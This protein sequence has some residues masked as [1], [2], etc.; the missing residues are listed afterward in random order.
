METNYHHNQGGV[1]KDVGNKRYL[2]NNLYNQQINLQETSNIESGHDDDIGVQREYIMNELVNDEALLNDFLQF[3]QQQAQYRIQKTGHNLIPYYENVSSNK[4]VTRKQLN[5]SKKLQSMVQ[6]QPDVSTP[7]KRRL[8][9]SAGSGGLPTPKQQ[10]SGNKQF[11]DNEIILD[12]IGDNRQIDSTSK[13]MQ[14]HKIPFDQVKRA[15]SSNLPCFYIGF[16]PTNEDQKVPSAFNAADKIFEYLKQK[17]VQINRF[18]FVGWAGVKLKL[19][20]NDKEDYINLVSTEEWPNSIMN[21]PITIEKPKFIPDC[22]ALVIRYIPHSMNYEFV[23]E[24]ISRSIASV[25]NLKRIQYAYNR[26]T[27]DYRFHVK[28]LQEYN[29]AINMRRIS[30]GNVMV[31]ITRFLEGNKLT[32]CTRCWRVGHMRNKCLDATARCRICLQEIIDIQKHN[33][34]QQPRCAQCDGNHHSLSS[35]CESIK[36][37]KVQ[38]KEEVENALARGVIHRSE[39]NKQVP[40]FNQDDFPHLPNHNP[41]RNKVSAWGSKQGPTQQ[42]TIEFTEITGVLTALNKQLSIMTDTNIRMEKKF[43]EMEMCMKH[44]TNALELLQK[45]MKN[46]LCSIREVME[47]MVNPLCELAKIQVKRKH[48]PFTNILEELQAGISN[49]LSKQNSDTQKDGQISKDITTLSAS[50]NTNSNTR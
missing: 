42:P 18:S 29:R 38:L 20:V 46:T 40:N 12:E 14:Q 21:I 15:V 35:Q 25:V 39:P 28:D 48:P 13:Y 23:K 7:N 4:Q 3:R 33:C 24:E 50:S 44:D 34:T 5:Q 17:N 22:F 1:Q 16:H 19:G 27:D 45:T 49:R 47:T 30:I 11:Q 10:R 9:D 41:N 26:K 37:Y 8:N 32:Y 2:A 43:E 6:V 36:A 31:P